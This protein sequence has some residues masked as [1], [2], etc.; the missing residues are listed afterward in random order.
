MIIMMNAVGIRKMTV[1]A[2]KFSHLFIHL[3]N[4]FV[5]GAAVEYRQ[6]IACFIS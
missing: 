2:S 3:F 4:K 5:H 6:R 1:C